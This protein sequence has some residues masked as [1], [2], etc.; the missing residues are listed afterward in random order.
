MEVVETFQVHLPREIHQYSHSWSDRET[1][2]IGTWRFGHPSE[3]VLLDLAMLFRLPESDGKGEKN[4]KMMIWQ[5]ML[6]EW[7][8]NGFIWWISSGWGPDTLL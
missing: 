5:K 7:E 3:I 1:G 2:L 6:E 4:E 8:V